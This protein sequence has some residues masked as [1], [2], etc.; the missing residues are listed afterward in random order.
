MDKYTIF[1]DQ[2]DSY[3]RLRLFINGAKVGKLVLRYDE[4]IP[5]WGVL[6]SA[7]KNRTGQWLIE[8]RDEK[9]WAEYDKRRLEHDRV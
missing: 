4:Y 1:V 3:V 6:Q 7:A 8:F 5:F 9:F 2:V